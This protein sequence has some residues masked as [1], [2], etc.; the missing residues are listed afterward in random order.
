MSFNRPHVDFSFGD[1]D[2]P[3]GGDGAEEELNND[4][5]LGV[6]KENWSAMRS[7]FR[8]HKVMD[9]LNVRM[10][11]PEVESFEANATEAL[12]SEWQSAGWQCRINASVGC[13]L[14]HK[15]SG[16][17]RYF[18]ASPNEGALF[19]KPQTVASMEGLQNFIQTVAAKDVQEHALRHRPN[20][21]WRLH[22]LT[23]ISF[24]LYKLQ[25]VSNVGAKDGDYF[26]TYLRQ[27]KHVLCLL[28]DPRTGKEYKDNLCF[29][30]CLAL[31]M[32]CRCQDS[33][34]CTV[35]KQR[36]TQSL[37][38]QYLEAMDMD[39]AE[40]CG[41]NESDLVDLELLFDITITVFSLKGCGRCD[42]LWRSKRHGGRKLN[43]NV[44]EEH[45]SYIRDVEALCRS[46]RCMVC[47]A[48]FTRATSAR[49]HC[50]SVENVTEMKY[51]T[52][53]LKP[54]VGVWDRVELETGLRVPQSL[55]FYP[56]WMTYDIESLLLK[57]NL[58][59]LTRTTTYH[60]RHELVSVSV[61]TNVPGY[62]QPKCFVR[63][64]TVDEC[65]D[66]FV[67][68]LA[69]VAYKAEELLRPKYR[70]LLRKVRNFIRERN[71]AEGQH[72]E[73]KFSNPRTY[74]SR[75]NLCN[76]QEKIDT[77][78]RQVPLVSFN[79]QNYDLHVMKAAL[80][81]SLH[82]VD[83]NG[84]EKSTIEHVV[85]KQEALACVSTDRLRI[86]DMVNIIG[87]GYTYDKYLK[88]FD[89]EQ[90][91]GYF[92]Y[93]WLDDLSKL[94]EETLPPIDAFFSKLKGQTIN[95]EE[96]ATVVE[97]WRANGMNCVRDLLEWYNNLDVAPF[98]QAIAKQREVYE[99][100]GIDMLKDAFSAPGIAVLWL[101][102]ETGKRKTIRQAFDLTDDEEE[103]F[104]RR[105]AEATVD[106]QRIHR[107]DDD[108]GS[109]LYKLFRSN[110][111]GGPSIVFHRE[112]ERGLTRLRERDLGAEAELC[113]VILGLDANALYLHCI[114]QDMPVGTP[115]VRLAE[116]GFKVEEGKSRYGKTAQGWLAWREF[117]DNVHIETAV[118]G[119]E[120]RLGQ[121][122]LPVD[123]FSQS[124]WTIYQFHGCY[125]HG[126]DC[127][128][129]GDRQ[130]AR[131]RTPEARREETS[132]KEEYLRSLGYRV[133]T[134]W[135]CEWSQLV[136]G[137]TRIKTFL[138]AFF[139]K[140]YGQMRSGMTESDILQR[141]KEGKLFGYVECDI[142]VP[143]SREDYFSE[144]SPIFKNM[145][146]SRDDLSAH[147]RQ[148]AEEEGFL[149]R[150]QRYLVG[151]MKGDKILLATELLRWYMEK[152][153]VVTKVY[154]VIEYERK[155]LFRRF[156]DSV[157]AA[158]RAG[159]ADPRL[160]LVADTN[161][162]IGNSAYG[163]LCQDKTK[164]KAVSYST[165][166]KTASD[167]IRSGLFHSLNII[168]D[169]VFEIS[170]FKKRVSCIL[171]HFLSLASCFLHL[172]H[173][174]TILTPGV[175]FCS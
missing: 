116:N 73:E 143:A 18:H 11:D 47:G 79:G 60:S 128:R 83:E 55:K 63:Q 106:V 160:K 138:S 96:Y 94:D 2:Q 97:A 81:R 31:L 28:T 85:K 170:C 64:T 26:P 117:E 17:F 8:C 146:L 61:C 7:F 57:S 156:G 125:W 42:I 142:H 76:I 75:A 154:K 169:D 111:V 104:Y 53:V 158:R 20:T 114:M 10:W 162:L 87:A 88:A 103:S 62:E 113:D 54:P 108:T 109:D 166:S 23:N 112:H 86:I 110:L 40:F 98:V 167:A 51:S 137:S 93:E 39:K 126:H 99:A 91:K 164:H 129:C 161:K 105:V 22:A 120:R 25:G 69:E 44:Y 27:N 102:R 131:G 9:V 52:G 89:V 134:I 29:F 1:R 90:R 168:D 107:F 46:F 32:D 12:S 95:E 127:D 159:D 38:R 68:Y 34:R 77:W 165:C 5:L 155:A 140:T 78:L 136:K 148:F 149:K 123:G 124:T 15:V 24:Y 130:D 37:F 141:V 58:P 145:E 36:T 100:K 14:M 82:A 72:A 174:L 3:F 172:L 132:R 118:N 147:M 33:C 139:A 35:P 59:E 50:C 163:K 151:S 56:Y 19:E 119:G 48:H 74:K 70:R 175:I 92:P 21:E 65:V 71:A 43:L 13:I 150:P 135:E 171:R 84:K 152:G 80:V 4:E 173:V 153:L 30:R 115:N 41:V 121:H 16:R 122:N 101:E 45:F 6:I 133:I 144:M 67:S 66:R 49:R 157:T